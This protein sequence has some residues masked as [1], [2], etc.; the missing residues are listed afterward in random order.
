MYSVYNNA[1]FI[2]GQLIIIYIKVRKLL[3]VSINEQLLCIGSRL[4]TP[5]PYTFHIP[6]PMVVREIVDKKV[7]QKIKNVLHIHSHRCFH[8]QLVFI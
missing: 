2:F 7:I 1:G 8:R 5:L 6:K 3:A 4:T